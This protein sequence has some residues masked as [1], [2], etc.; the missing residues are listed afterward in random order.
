[1]DVEEEISL[2]YYLTLR[3]IMFGNLTFETDVNF[4][5]KL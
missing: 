3:T 2:F 5:K 4:F 1:M